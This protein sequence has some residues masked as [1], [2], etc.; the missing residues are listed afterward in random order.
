MAIEKEQFK[1]IFT[2]EK[3][4]GL[5]PKDR[6]DRFFDALYGDAGEGA[7]DIGFAFNGIEGNRLLFEFQLT[8]RK[9]K[10]LAC[11]L[12]YGLPNVFS[13]HPIIDVKGLVEKIDG[14]LGGSP[15]IVDWKLGSTCEISRT[16]HI[17][18]LIL[19]IT[20]SG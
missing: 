10:C 7:Y 11:N 4:A 2:P 13:R 5:F 18:P 6:S 9:G 19:S 16:L 3:L 12:T 1:R 8:Q 15:K 17:V 20:V 14:L